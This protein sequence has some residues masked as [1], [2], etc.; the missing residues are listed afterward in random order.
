M[1]IVTADLKLPECPNI[2]IKS[3]Y[4]FLDIFPELPYHNQYQEQ[5]YHQ[6]VP[7]TN[8]PPTFIPTD[9]AMDSYPIFKLHSW[10]STEIL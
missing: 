4:L 9:L 10:A 2:L 8:A 1:V 6:E 7:I 5:H 3:C